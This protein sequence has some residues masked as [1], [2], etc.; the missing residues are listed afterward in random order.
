MPASNCSDCIFLPKYRN[1]LLGKFL[2]VWAIPLIS[3]M[4]WILVAA[5]RLFAQQSFDLDQFF[6]KAFLQHEFQP[7]SFGPARW[8]NEGE[9]YA[10][11]EPS[12]SL[13][14]AS[15]LARY[16]TATGKREVLIAA[17]D[18]IPT[19]SKDPIHIENYDWSGDMSRVLIYTNSRKVWRANTRGDYW[20]F[21][22]RGKSLRKLGGDASPSTLMF[23]K[24]SPDGSRVAY[25]RA[26]NIYVESA[27]TGETIQLTHDGSETIINGTT[28]WVYE[29]EF[30]LRDAF[31][32]SPDG[33]RIAYWQF[34]TSG[35]RK[36][37]LLYNVGAP[38]EVLTHIPYPE[39]GL[40]PQIKE[41]AYPEPGTANSSVRAGVVSSDGGVTTW[42]QVPGDP[43]NN[44]I[45]RM[46]WAGDSNTLV[47]Q[48]LNRLQNTNDV[49]LADA[50]NGTVQPVYGDH[51][52]AWVDVVE[53]LQWLHGGKE[54]L[55]LS[56]QDGWRRAYL[57]SRDGKQVRPITPG[58]SD[59]IQL[60]GTTP[61]EDWLYYLA[62]PDNATQRYL[63]RSK[64]DGGGKA[65]RLTPANQPGMHSYQFSPDFHWA[66]HSYS[67][68]DS[69]PVTDL[70]NVPDHRVTRVL[71]DNAALR[72]NLK[73]FL[74]RPTEFIHVDIGDG[75]TL[76][77]WMMKPRNFD[78]ARKY[79][80]LVYVYGEPAGQ[81]V[82]D[83]WEGESGLFHRAMTESGYLVVSVD[84]RG[85]PAPKG[86]AWRKIVYGSVGVLSSVEQTKALQVLERTYPFMDANRIAVWGWS[87]GGSNT[88]NLMFR[89]P[90]VYKAGMS[91]A[92]VA[93]QR[94]YDTIYQERYMGIPQDNSEGYRMGSPINFAE[95]LRGKLLIVHSPGD[96]NVHYQGTELLINRLVELGKP[97]DFMEYPGRT[98]SLAEGKGTHYH[99]YSLL[100]RY[101]L[102]HVTPGPL[103]E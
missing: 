64:L 77:G 67:R 79:P 85:T 8:L 93:D 65:E 29:E 49:L 48:H 24:F 81:T 88:L 3:S 54:F 22:R 42:L 98:H 57:V 17:S 6:R 60:V 14:G 91:V 102:E 12:S 7:K 95:G 15:E 61:Q 11:L 97:F 73:D 1:P 27:Q 75:V 18:L 16:D 2:R 56:E 23:A 43:T 50:N 87:G 103:R 37:G 38:Y 62:S 28:D 83:S 21:D 34:N 32:W 55:W 13:S 66:I 47:L 51:D 100:A 84:N 26:N 46:E 69:P 31:R 59:V 4:V 99:V 40:Y 82:V 9:A 53:H 80:V 78:P 68:F 33:K 5:T 94:L 35:V 44:Y 89:S 41:I 52:S 71:E 39:Y 58:N 92:P 72:A 96:D 10:T 70:V 25:V 45:A 76:D 101:L 90:D 36:F 20:V 63:Y 74:S 19:G 30:F 86:R